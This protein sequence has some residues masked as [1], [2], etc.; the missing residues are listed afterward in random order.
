[1]TNNN[2][3][4]NANIQNFGFSIIDFWN[5]FAI[6]LLVIGAYLLFEYCDL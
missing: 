1:M 5:L 4:P 2:Q 3:I 6:W